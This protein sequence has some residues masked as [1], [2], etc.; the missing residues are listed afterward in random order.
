MLTIH[1]H[2]EP[3][4]TPHKSS[5][6]VVHATNYCIQPCKPGVVENLCGLHLPKLLIYHLQIIINSIGVLPHLLLEILCEAL[7]TRCKPSS[8]I[9]IFIS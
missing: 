4:K 9:I 7:G 6:M 3:I 8:V 5:E 2:V 1:P